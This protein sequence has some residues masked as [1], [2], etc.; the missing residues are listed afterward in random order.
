MSQRTLLLLTPPTT[1]PR[2][3]RTVVELFGGWAGWS[4]GGWVFGWVGGWVGGWVCGCVGGLF[5]T[6]LSAFLPVGG[7]HVLY[8]PPL[9]WRCLTSSPQ[10]LSVPDQA[11]QLPPF[12][13]T[14]PRPPS[15]PPL[16]SERNLSAAPTLAP[17][18]P[19]PQSPHL[20][21]EVG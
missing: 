6:W 12:G 15:T 4:L 14:P 21:L 5:R 18:L 19:T 10:Y 3:R 8:C 1:T 16:L 2:T 17:T 13:V 9:Y 20:Q 7:G 11:A